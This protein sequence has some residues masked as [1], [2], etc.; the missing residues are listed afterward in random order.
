MACFDKSRC[1]Q[2]LS[3]GTE[4]DE[5]TEA[6]GG[7]GKFAPSIKGLCDADLRAIG[8]SRHQPAVMAYANEKL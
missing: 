3:D 2:A 6:R 5:A 4:T 7:L 8:C 1:F